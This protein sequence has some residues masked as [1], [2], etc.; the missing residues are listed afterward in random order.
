M[1]REKK[2]WRTILSGNPVNWSCY[3]P[4]TLDPNASDA[5]GPWARMVR[6]TTVAPDGRRLEMVLTPALAREYARQI[7]RQADA[8]DDVNRR[9]GNGFAPDYERETS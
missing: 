8:L 9:H 2:T 1:A 3:N 4:E 6:L 5:N 7:T